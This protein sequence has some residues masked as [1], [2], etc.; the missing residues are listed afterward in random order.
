MEFLLLFCWYY[1]V[2][3]EVKPGRILGQRIPSGNG[4]TFTTSKI[5][6]LVCNYV[7]LLFW[8]PSKPTQGG[9]VRSGA[10]AATVSATHDPST[11]HPLPRRSRAHWLQPPLQCLWVVAPEC[12][13][14]SLCV[15]QQP[16]I[17]PW[18][19]L[20]LLRDNVWKETTDEKQLPCSSLYH[21]P[22]LR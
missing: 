13:R 9:C 14:V 4:Q 8:W 12:G 19:G 18:F 17:C 15:F 11:S 7:T 20:P 10:M 1:T 21:E 2:F 16:S 3:L 5:W 6:S 22:S